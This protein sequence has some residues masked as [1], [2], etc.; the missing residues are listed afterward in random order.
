MEFERIKKLAE[1]IE[2][3]KFEDLD[4]RGY[5]ENTILKPE[6]TLKEV[7]EFCR[8]STGIRVLWCLR[9]PVFCFLSEG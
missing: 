9:K 1:E 6:A 5:I 4:L 3:G 8:K 7:E 2:K